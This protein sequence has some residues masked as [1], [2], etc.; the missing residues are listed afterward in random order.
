MGKLAGIL[1]VVAAIAAGAYVYGT[2]VQANRK[3]TLELQLKEN[4]LKTAD[5]KKA[6]AALLE[7]A[8]EAELK[9]AEAARKKA[10]AEKASAEAK[11][12]AAKQEKENLEKRRAVAAA[13]EKK[14][15][16]D[17]KMAE[18][19]AEKSTAAAKESAA[20]KE[21]AEAVKAKEEVE[22]RRAESERR[23]AEAEYATA[24]AKKA[25]AEAELKKSEN[26]RKT[27]EAKAAAEHDAKL[28]M[29]RRAETS[30]AEKLEL[31]RAERLLA[32][33]E[34][35][36]LNRGATVQSAV[37]E[38]DDEEEVATDGE[39]PENG[40]GEERPAKKAKMVED[41]VK[42]DPLDAEL[43]RLVK[44]LSGDIDQVRAKLAGRYSAMLK[45]L[46]EDAEKEGREVDAAR[47]RAAM[48]SLVGGEL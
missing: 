15:H 18:A 39:M 37:A 47:Y 32:A 44:S 13:E 12:D 26:D 7:K 34:A 33:E 16:A 43:E 25:T 4:K 19:E 8:K 24:A 35:G 11:R 3:L 20:A 22:L 2:K 28:R 31:E 48:Q 1:T 14:A 6:E 30:R 40:S 23:R 38:D 45:R 5:V 27:A 17:A 46:A 36:L 41:P 21:A 29:Y 10:E 9:T 42:I